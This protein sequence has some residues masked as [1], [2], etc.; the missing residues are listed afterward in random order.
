MR[1][2]LEFNIPS[3]LHVDEF[4][5]SGGLALAAELGAVSGD[6][7][8]KS[9]APSRQA[10]TDTGTMQTFLPGTPYVLGNPLDLPLQ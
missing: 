10:A 6:H 3:R 5:D 9:T 8:A 1:A 4:E 2:A 7:A